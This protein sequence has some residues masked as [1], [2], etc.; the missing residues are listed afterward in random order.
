MR[1]QINNQIQ[2]EIK[3][4]DRSNVIQRSINVTL[5]C[6]QRASCHQWTCTLLPV[7]Q[8][9]AITQHLF[10][11]LGSWG[12][13]GH[14]DS[15]WCCCRHRRIQWCPWSMGVMPQTL[16]CPH[17]HALQPFQAMTQSSLLYWIVQVPSLFFFALNTKVQSSNTG[18]HSFYWADPEWTPEANQCFAFKSFSKRATRLPWWSSGSES[19]CQGGWHGFDPWSGKIP[20]AMGQLGG[21][22]G[23]TE[24]SIPFLIWSPRES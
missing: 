4:R 5:W 21:C 23:T 17:L 6:S 15:W 7:C 2:H 22:T 11:F 8:H 9:S 13:T 19:A 20:H 16:Y 24:A 3:Q 12:H 1:W 14:Q 10:C 18:S